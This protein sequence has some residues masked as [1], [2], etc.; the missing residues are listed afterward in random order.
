MLRRMVGLA[1]G[2]QRAASANYVCVNNYTNS[3]TLDSAFQSTARI[4]GV[5]RSK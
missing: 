3:E 2:A 5:D 1:D 4:V